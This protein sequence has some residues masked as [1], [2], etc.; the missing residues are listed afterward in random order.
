MKNG[1]GWY[2]LLIILGIAFMCITPL[3]EMWIWNWVIVDLF[4]APAV[5]FWQ[6]LGIHWLCTMLFRN[7]ITVKRD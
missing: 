4:A 5:D 7:V 1:C 3:F 2:I 6:M